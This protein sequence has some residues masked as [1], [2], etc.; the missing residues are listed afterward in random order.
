MIKK[1][2]YC[3]EESTTSSEN[4]C[5]GTGNIKRGTLMFAPQTSWS[6]SSANLTVRGKC[7]NEAA[8]DNNI[9]P[10]GGNDAGYL[11]ALL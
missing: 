6:V 1:S 2:C 11:Q 5:L 3:V 4:I 10:A 9:P 8:K 7:R